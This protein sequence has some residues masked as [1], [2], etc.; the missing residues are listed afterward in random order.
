MFVNFRKPL[1]TADRVILLNKLEHYGVRWIPNRLFRTD[2]T[3]RTQFISVGNHASSTRE[4]HWHTTKFNSDDLLFFLY[5][6]ELHKCLKNCKA[7]FFADGTNLN[8]T[9]KYLQ[10]L[11]KKLYN[12]NYII[13]LKILSHFDLLRADELSLNFQ[14]TE[15]VLF[16]SPKLNVKGVTKICLMGKG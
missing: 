9:S 10:T 12:K 7:Y 16:Q 2:L 1:Y 13:I 15:F 4:L 5:M 11:A 14:K 3:E 8:V 6:N